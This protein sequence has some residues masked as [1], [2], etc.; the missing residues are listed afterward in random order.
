M[1]RLSVNV[2]P[3]TVVKD[4]FIVPLMDRFGDRVLPIGDQLDRSPAKN[5]F[6]LNQPIAYFWT[7]S[8]A[9]REYRERAD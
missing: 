1:G 5:L 8:N 7:K 9:R 4:L 2:R 3:R 6:R